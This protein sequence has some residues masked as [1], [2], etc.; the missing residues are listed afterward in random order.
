[1]VAV[2]I[3]LGV[4]WGAIQA[5]RTSAKPMPVPSQV[6][7]FRATTTHRQTAIPLPGV[8]LENSPERG[9]V[10]LP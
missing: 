9:H 2:G 8:R 6:T 4:L 1:M 5:S 10:R 7:A 3:G